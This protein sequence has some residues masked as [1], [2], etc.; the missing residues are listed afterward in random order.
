MQYP[1]KRLLDIIA[2]VSCLILLFPIL[3]GITVLI[4]VF[5]GWPVIFCQ[6]RAGLR[7]R[8]FTI[9]K[10]RTMTDARNNKGQL[11]PDENRLTRF[12]RFLRSTSLDE[13]PEFFNVLRGKM[14][15][16]G[17]RP[18]HVRYQDRYT[19]EQRRREEVKPGI[20]GWSQ[21]KGRN[22]QTWEDRFVYDVWYV[23]HWSLW[24]DIKILIITA[25]KVLFM[26]DINAPGEATMSEFMGSKYI[27]TVDSK[28]SGTGGKRQA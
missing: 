1:A 23:D 5:L 6:E 7:G 15:L 26:R 14:S 11:L 3:A 28:Q 2:S 25:W 10:F 19:P 8:R 13:L 27:G 9:Y 22:V 18:L 21:I 20:T 16:V 17:P 24:L 4:A 12:G